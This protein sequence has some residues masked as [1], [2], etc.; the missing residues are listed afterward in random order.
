MEREVDEFFREVKEV[1]KKMMEESVESQ[2][3]KEK[4]KSEYAAWKKK[5][6]AEAN[7]IC[8]ELAEQNKELRYLEANPGPRW[9]RSLIKRLFGRCHR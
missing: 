6:W 4:T 7:R 2:R 8:A 9:R 3:E 5:A 1:N